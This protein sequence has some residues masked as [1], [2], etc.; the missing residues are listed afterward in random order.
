MSAWAAW[1]AWGLVA[2]L[3]GLV[4]VL[5]PAWI[6]LGFALGAALVALGLLT[7]ALGPIVALSGGYGLALLL[8]LFAATSILSWLALRRAFGPAAGE[9]TVFEDDVND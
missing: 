5:A 6:A 2:L 3:L 4:E 7:G 9:R 8:L 1:W